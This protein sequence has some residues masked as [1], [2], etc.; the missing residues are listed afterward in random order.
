VVVVTGTGFVAYGLFCLIT[1]RYR[2]L[3]RV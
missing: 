3:E 2:H 1:F